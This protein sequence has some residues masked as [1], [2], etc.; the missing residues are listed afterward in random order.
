MLTAETQTWLQALSLALPH[1]LEAPFL[2]DLVQGQSWL[3][4]R[5]QDPSPENPTFSCRK[6]DFFQG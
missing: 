3:C 5:L 6:L 1:T 4:V 2:G